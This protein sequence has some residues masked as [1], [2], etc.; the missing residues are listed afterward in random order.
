MML[1]AGA[2]SFGLLTIGARMAGQWEQARMAIDQ[3]V[4]GG[5]KA[6]R[7]VTDL[8]EFSKRSGQQLIAV[9]QNSQTLMNAGFKPDN[10]METMRAISG[11]AAFAGR[12]QEGFA[13]IAIALAQIQSKGRVMGEEMNGQLGEIM[14]AWDIMG[15]KLGKTRKELEAMAA[16]GKLTSDIAIPALISGMNERFGKLV[17]KQGTTLFGQL[18]KVMTDLQ[19]KAVGLL[20]LAKEFVSVLDRVVGI[21]GAINPKIIVWGTVLLF[22]GGALGKVIYYGKQAREAMLLLGVASE[23]SAKGFT[24]ANISAKGLLSTMY[25]FLVLPAAAATSIALWTD[26][27]RLF[28]GSLNFSGSN[29]LERLKDMFSGNFWR[30]TNTVKMWKALLGLGSGE[31]IAKELNTDIKGQ[32]DDVAKQMAQMMGEMTPAVSVIDS[33]NTKLALAQTK[34]GLLGNDLYDVMGD[35]LSAYQEALDGLLSQ[36]LD[37]TDQRIQSITASIK[38]LSAAQEANREATE[39]QKNAYKA[40]LNVVLNT[41]MFRNDAYSQGLT[42]ALDIGG[43][44]RQRGGKLDVVIRT[45]KG[46]VVEIVDQRMNTRDSAAGYAATVGAY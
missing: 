16:A 37:P 27:V 25:R 19:L 31:N 32:F 41:R 11:A 39:R 5:E 35:Q 26:V 22:A 43:Q 28:K 1:G 15:Q 23:T 20:P 7:M 24:L 10:M 12:G 18:N 44:L 9:V 6:K 14:P 13:R 8:T 17:D 33:L 4:G 38:Q 34:Y 21:V 40:L 36:G 46:E 3:M 2:A 29:G 45:V 42:D 30:K